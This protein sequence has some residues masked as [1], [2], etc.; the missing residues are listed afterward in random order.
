MK[1]TRYTDYALRA[2]IYLAAHDGGLVSIRQIAQ[3]HDISQNHLMK[4]IQDLG[5][6]GFVKTTRGRHG[7]L[8]LARPAAEITIG[9]VVRHTEGDSRLV[10]CSTCRIAE[11]CSLPDVFSEAREAFLAVLDKCHLS[12]AA[13]T[14]DAFR[15]LFVV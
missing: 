9:Q 2:L 1:L 8:A 5:A 10:D 13:R 7:G 12:D 4:I 6:A 3:A 14:P 15:H 11:G